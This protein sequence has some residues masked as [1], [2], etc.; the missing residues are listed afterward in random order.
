MYGEGRVAYKFL[1]RYILETVFHL[2][3]ALC[4]DRS[5]LGVL[6]EDER[7]RSKFCRIPEFRTR[8]NNLAVVFPH[9]YLNDIQTD[10]DL[11]LLLTAFSEQTDIGWD[12]FLCG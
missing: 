8:I 3:S 4:S 9:S 5:D 7:N 12:R 1:R 6:G 11:Q 10:P 2:C